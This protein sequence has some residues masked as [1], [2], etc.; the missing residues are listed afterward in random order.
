MIS[1]TELLECYLFNSGFHVWVQEKKRANN[2]A[3]R[4]ENFLDILAYDNSLTHTDVNASVTTYADVHVVNYAYMHAVIH[5]DVHALII[6][7]VYAVTNAN[8]NAV[9]NADEHSRF[10]HWF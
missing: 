4:F 10:C 2:W 3:S 1:A 5:V 8:V 9:T 7:I 6:A